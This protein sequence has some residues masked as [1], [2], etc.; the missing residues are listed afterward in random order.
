M[1]ASHSLPWDDKPPMKG[2]TILLTDT[3]KTDGRFMLHVLAS[4]HVSIYNNVNIIKSKKSNPRHHYIGGGKLIWISCASET[5]NQ[6]MKSINMHYDKTSTSSTT[7]TTM[8]KSSSFSCFEVTSA[9]K[10]TFSFN[11]NN[12]SEDNYLH[13]LCLRMLPKKCKKMMIRKLLL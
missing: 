1:D 6:I 9:P 11:D 13:Q 10:E 2:Q 5:E 7:T 8:K 3:I 12:N 4:Q